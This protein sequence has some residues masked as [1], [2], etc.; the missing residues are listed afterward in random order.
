MVGCFAE[1]PTGTGTGST[2]TG[3]VTGES[4]A[5]ISESL[6]ETTAPP[7]T[8]PGT[9]D[10]SSTTSSGTGSTSTGDGSSSSSGVV[11]ECDE[12]QLEV[13]GTCLDPL[14]VSSAS[15]VVDPPLPQ[16]SAMPCR[17]VS[18]PEGTLALAGGFGLEAGRVHSTHRT[19]AED[20]WVTCAGDADGSAPRWQ[21]YGRCST[22]T[23]NAVT[24]TKEVTYAV[25]DYGCEWA[26]CPEGT[27]VVGGGGR[28]GPAFDFR[29]SF[30]AVPSMNPDA[31]ERWVVCGSAPDEEVTIE[32]DVQCAVLPEGSGL[33]L[34]E[35][36]VSIDTGESVC[37]EASCVTG[38]AVAGGANVAATGILEGSFPDDEGDTWR[39]C[40]RVEGNIGA[41]LSARV[42]CLQD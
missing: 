13:A 2:S 17:D 6:G 16:P 34:Y 7:T 21:T 28:W 32:I 42:W 19:A 37:V 41:E 4:T 1:P 12:S 10:D 8:G 22:G 23:G 38:V 5:A 39:A 40:G 24:L 33:Q 14:N 20:G 30:P 15:T 9:T 27:R 35:E 31:P 3:A 18:C 25:T 36:F 26:A 11:V 29:G